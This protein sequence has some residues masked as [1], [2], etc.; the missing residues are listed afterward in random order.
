MNRLSTSIRIAAIGSAALVLAACAGKAVVDATPAPVAASSAA[1]PVAA[2]PTDADLPRAKAAA[3]AFSS[4]LRE[5]L[6][7]QMGQ[8][9]PVAAVNF[10]ASEAPVIAETVGREYGVRLGRVA[11]SG[12][13]RNSANV[14]QGWQAEALA[15]VSA[16]VA[17]GGKPQDQVVVLRD[18]LPAGVALGFF[19]GIA[20]EPACLGCHGS[21]I[22]P[23]VAA[24]IRA[25]YPADRATGFAAGDLRGGLWVEVPAG[26]AR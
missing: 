17:G 26:T 9:G 11:V 3:Q 12:R 16:A 4:R 1:T 5:Q 18:G 22:A 2:A 19:K 21:N 8:G 23:P 6:M 25:Q 20:V 15:K 24:A 13:N 7:Q 10:C 14:A